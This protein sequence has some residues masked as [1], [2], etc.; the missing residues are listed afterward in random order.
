MPGTLLFAQKN[1]LLLYGNVG[2]QSD[3]SSSDTKDSKV[4]FN[5]AIGYQFDDNW[6]AG[7]YLGLQSAKHD[8]STPSEPVIK[9]TGIAAGP[10][11]RYAKSLGGIFAVYGQLQGG[12]TSGEVKSGSTTLYKTTGFET[13]LFPAFGINVHNGLALNVDFGGISYSGY[14][15]KG[16]SGNNNSFDFNFGQNFTIG[17]S[18]NF[19]LKKS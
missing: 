2:Y 19:S 15:V 18:K 4:T 13:K 1:S 5:P 3:K 7:A 6:T 16:T 10:F 9:A 11:I 17:I 12:F 14:K 8:P